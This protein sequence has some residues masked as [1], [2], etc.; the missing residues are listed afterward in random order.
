M[1]FK[2]RSN[3]YDRGDQP[4]AIKDL[5]GNIR[6]GSDEQVLLG[7]T[8][9][10]KTYT[11]ARVIENVSQPTLVISHNKTLTAQLY[12]EF[13]SFFP[14][15]AVEYFV[16]YYD[17]YQPEAYIPQSDTYIEKDSSINER[18]D[19]LRLKAT[20]SLL[21]RKDVIVVAS[22]SCIYGI[23]SPEQW[24]TR[25]I[26]FKKGDQYPRSTISKDLTALRYERNDI[27]FARGV[28]RI[29]GPV[30]DIFPAYF[31]NEAVRIQLDGDKIVSI[32]T[33]DPLTGKKTNEHDRFIIYPATHFVTQPDTLN[34]AMQLIKKELSQQLKVLNDNGKYLEAQRLQMRTEYDLEMMKETGYC[35]GIEN[36]SRHISGRPAG[37]ASYCLID[38]FPQ[39]FL[40][41]IDESHVTLPQ[42]RGMYAGDHS[43]KTTLVE[44]GFR[45]PSALDNRPLKF[46][47][48]EKITD[49]IIYVS[50]TPSEYE[51]NRENIRIVEQ[52]IRPTGLVDPEIEIRPVENQVE[53]LRNEIIT[54]ASNNTRVLVTTLTKKMSEDLT[55]YLS[56]KGLRVEYL[57]SEIDTMKR[58]DILKN[59]RKGEFDCLIGVNLLREGLDLPEVTLVAVLD[60]DKEGFLRSETSLIQ[61]CGR[62]A[63]NINGRV[64]MYADKITGSMKRAM[65][66]MS[67]R[68]KIQD[69]YNKEHDITPKSIVKAVREEKEFNYEN[70]KKAVKH[71]RDIGWE[72]DPDKAGIGIIR[73]LEQDMFQAADLLD[74][75]LAAA[76]RDKINDIKKQRNRRNS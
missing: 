70:K 55:Q 11:M 8:G 68:R 10:G 74:F 32:S 25:I 58:I 29:R 18:I 21:S 71:I 38:Y 47:E 20:S 6:K 22:V 12:S 43:R 60:A 39:E 30:I 36:Y 15:N 26:T 28:F 24:S 9:S 62:A 34:N 75:E 35:S 16:S 1:G 14:E 73:D 66:E 4:R 49:K 41:M 46:G 3:Y 33:I 53:D 64:V 13:K 59:L 52:I 57:H 42:L 2:L 23:G 44:H 19:Q 51:L 72:I 48:F 63:R 50:A 45:L 76:I 40:T 7:V 65:N 5:S 67:R 37:E 56:S 69:S 54:A 27:A 61:V 31:D 17:Y